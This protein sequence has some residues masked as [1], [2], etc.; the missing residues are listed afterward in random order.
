VKKGRPA[1]SSG[2]FNGGCGA[3]VWGWVWN[4]PKRGDVRHVLCEANGCGAQ[5]GGARQRA[6]VRLLTILPAEGL[7]KNSKGLT[8][9]REERK[10][11]RGNRTPS[12]RPPRFCLLK[13][14][15][16]RCRPKEKPGKK[17]AHSPV[18]T[19]QQGECTY[20]KKGEKGEGGRSERAGAEHRL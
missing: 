5:G 18:E 9:H 16:G 3:D 11:N 10:P 20:G 14:H 15:V 12:S 2:E 4:K 6:E 13:Y 19:S 7:S 1:I 17:G 8:E